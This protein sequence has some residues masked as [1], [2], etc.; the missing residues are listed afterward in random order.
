MTSIDRPTVQ[1]ELTCD[2]VSE[3]AGLYVLDALE[4]SE[5]EQV[6][7][8]LASCAEAHAEVR[9]LGGVVPALATM[10][11][12]VE[13]PPELKARVMAAIA[14]EPRVATSTPNATVGVPVSEP[15]AITRQ[16]P[17]FAERQV[18]ASQRAAGRP[19]VWASWGAAIAAVLVL[20]VVGVWAL[21]VQSRADEATRRDAIVSEA[22][23][24]FSQPG[25]SV[26]VL[27]PSGTGTTSG[28]GFAAVSAD[29]KAYVVMVGLPEAPSGRTYQAWFIRDNQPSSAGLMTVDR[30]GYAVMTNSSPLAGAQVIALTVEP[31]GG[32]AAPTSDPFALGEIRPV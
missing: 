24:A 25:S 26:A 28:T 21:G 2:E 29:G 4:P 27:R 15:G 8:H 17:V 6:R 5:R 31:A 30:D 9:D 16:R 1:P 22:I 13:S 18:V 32:S 12:P 3:L 14:A 20:A 11:E 10:A 7:A 19:P 23:A